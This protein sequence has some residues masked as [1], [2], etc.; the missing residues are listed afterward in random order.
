M[1]VEDRR[2]PVL[3]S[4]G[5]DG[6]GVDAHL[7]VGARQFARAE[8][9]QD[10]VVMQDDDQLAGNGSPVRRLRAVAEQFGRALQLLFADMADRIGDRRGGL[11]AVAVD[12]QQ[13]DRQ[14]RVDVEGGIVA[15]G[16]AAEAKGVRHAGGPDRGLPIGG[17]HRIAE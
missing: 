1:A 2:G 10:Q 4:K 3:A 9:R 6:L 14:D 11:T 13:V 12:Q 17:G 5:Q 7:E 8:S 15:A 16:Q